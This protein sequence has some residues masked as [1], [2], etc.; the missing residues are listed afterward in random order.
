MFKNVLLDGL[1]LYG[2]REDPKDAA[3]VDRD[4]IEISA[5]ERPFPTAP[6]MHYSE[7]FCP[8]LS[9]LDEGKVDGSEAAHCVQSLE[10]PLQRS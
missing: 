2:V 7:I 1:V 4:H 3:R 6:A 9:D 10:S 5:R 8:Y